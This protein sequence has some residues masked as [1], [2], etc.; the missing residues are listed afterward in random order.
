MHLI[1][2]PDDN[3]YAPNFETIGGPSYSAAILLNP[4]NLQVLPWK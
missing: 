4:T 3:Y 1:I 2:T